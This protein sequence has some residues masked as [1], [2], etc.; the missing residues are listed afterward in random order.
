MIFVIGAKGRLGQA[1]AKSYAVHSPVCP[2]RSDYENWW[3]EG[4]QA[5][6]ARYFAQRAASNSTVFIA[7]GVLDPKISPDIHSHVNYQLPRNVME[8]VAGRGMKVVTFGTVM[9]RMPATTNPYIMSK[10]RLGQYVAE[11]AN[12]G[13]AV[14]HFQIH[15]LYGQGAP[16]PFMFLGQILDALQTATEFKMTLGKQLREYHHIDDCVRA[17]RLLLDSGINGVTHI[18]RG[19]PLGLNV[20][21][22]HIFR[23]FNAQKLLKIGALPEPRSENYAMVFDRPALLSEMNFRETLPAVVHYLKTCIGDLEAPA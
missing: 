14:T 3:H 19:E 13:S 6:I 20:L 2:N 17:V 8:A 12:T 5:E 23:A 21:A 16:S 1:I 15:T 7:A 18:S 22:T 10:S 11:L 4:S 9:E